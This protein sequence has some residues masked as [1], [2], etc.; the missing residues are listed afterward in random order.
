M[1]KNRFVYQ[2]RNPMK[3][4]CADGIVRA[5]SL[6]LEKDWL[7]VYSDLCALGAQLYRMPNDKECYKVYLLRHGFSRTGI[8][9]Q[10]GSKRPTVRSF[11]ESHP[12]GTYILQIAQ[13]LVAVKDGRFFDTVDCSNKCLYGYWMRQTSE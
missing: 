6:A 1:S 9:H 7:Q 8:S 4:E 13:H 11:V 2:N 12:R 5:I 10:K 3:Q